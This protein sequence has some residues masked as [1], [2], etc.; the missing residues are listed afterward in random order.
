MTISNVQE[1]L[2]SWFNLE[3]YPGQ[4][5]HVL[6]INQTWMPNNYFHFHLQPNYIGI[7]CTHLNLRQIVERSAD[8]AR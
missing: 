4:S 7:I 6:S 3:N 2:S 1:N 8:F 5:K